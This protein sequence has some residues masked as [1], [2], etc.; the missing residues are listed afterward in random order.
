[1]AKAFDSKERCRAG[2]GVC[3]CLIAGDEDSV[4]LY[5]TGDFET[6][7]LL[8]A[9]LRIPVLFAL[10]DRHYQRRERKMPGNPYIELL[11]HFREAYASHGDYF[12]W[13]AAVTRDELSAHPSLREFLVTAVPLLRGSWYIVGDIVHASRFCASDQ[14]RA[15]RSATLEAFCKLAYRAG[16]ALPLRIRKAIAG[17]PDD[18][19]AG[20]LSSWV[21]FLWHVFP[22]SEEDLT[23]HE[24][25]SLPLRIVCRNPFQASMDA[26]ELC[27][28]DTAQPQFPPVQEQG[29]VATA[30][31][32]GRLSVERA[33]EKA[34][35]LARRLRAGFFALSERQQAEMIG[36]HWQT[37]TK[38]PFYSQVGQKGLLFKKGT[39]SSPKTES[40]TSGREAVIGEGDRDEVLNNLIAE[41]EAD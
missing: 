39:K 13:F 10:G 41:Q 25:E 34:V 28:L 19:P 33:N 26:I 30:S 37:W 29:L 9:H 14:Y 5:T 16:A 20:P 7:C 15:L 22:P 18:S 2:R 27:M 12:L 35:K 1:M 4:L 31:A 8:P 36:C 11:A 23:P 40:L 17:S 24:G 6:S 38:T 3:W 32:R 21:T